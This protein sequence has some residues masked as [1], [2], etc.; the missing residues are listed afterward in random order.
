MQHAARVYWAL[1]MLPLIKRLAR[2]AAALTLI[3]LGLVLSIPGIPGPGIL[4]IL[5][6][7]FVL[8]PEN[9]R[10]RKKYG[11]LKPRYPRIL[12]PIGTRRGRRRDARHAER[13]PRP[14]P[15]RLRSRPMPRN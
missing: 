7:I 6:G 14:L 10:L 9:R 1:P 8:L 13:P 11:A 5:I 3:V 4:V 12:R 15:W 2:W